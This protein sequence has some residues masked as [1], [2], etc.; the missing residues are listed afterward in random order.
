M[1]SRWRNNS[2]PGLDLNAFLKEAE[3]TA[4]GNPTGTGVMSPAE[5]AR[6]LGLQSNGKGGYVDPNSGQVV[7]QTVNGELVFYSQNRASG[8][9]VSDSSGGASLVKDQPSWA[10]PTTG[11]TITPPGKPESPEEQGSVPDPVPAKAPHGYNSFMVQQKQQAYEQD[12]QQQEMPMG[13]QPEVPIDAEG[14][15][16]GLELPVEEQYTGPDLAKRMGKMGFDPT[17]Q[18]SAGEMAK[19]ALKKGKTLQQFSQPTERQTNLQTR[20]GG[21]TS[22]STLSKGA[23]SNALSLEDISSFRK[24]IKDGPQNKREEISDEDVDYSLGFLK[25]QSG[26][27]WSNFQA[28]LK[29]KGDPE[30]SRKVVSRAREIVKSYLENY[31]QSAVDGS[32]L[33]FS[34]SE[35]DHGMS[36][37]NGGLDEGS[38]W[39]WLPKRFNQFKS[40]LSDEELMEALDKEETKLNDPDYKIKQSQDELTNFSRKEWRERFENRSDQLN[41]ADIRQAKGSLGMQLLKSLA[42]KNGVS[43]YKDRGVTRASGRAGGGTSLGVSELQDRLIDELGIPDEVDISKFDKALFESLQKI[44]DKRSELDSAKRAQSKRKRELKKLN[45][46]K[47]G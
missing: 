23:G 40:D 7:A 47:E 21:L 41:V 45:L 34:D 10:D 43:Y 44:E 6:Q 5:R 33:P 8:G 14:G 29:G 35:L 16:P 19:N 42:E 9:A 26:P 25:E 3:G 4:P 36:L 30:P 37:S 39:R 12:S 31:G 22:P 38:N 28:R 20:L 13:D 11:M 2:N 1:T 46:K 27:K 17:Q 32:E 24:Y 18:A 15:Q